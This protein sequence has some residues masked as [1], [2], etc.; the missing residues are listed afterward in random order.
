MR[1]IA[2]GIMNGFVAVLILFPAIVFAAPTG[3]VEEIG[4]QNTYRPGCWTPML[5]SIHPDSAVGTYTLQ[6]VQ[7]DLDKDRVVYSRSIA[8]AGGTAEQRFWTC[9]LPQPTDGG[10]PQPVEGLAALQAQLKVYLATAEGK[11]IVQL[12]V[13]QTITNIDP[14]DSGMNLQRGNKLILAIADPASGDGV[15]RVNYNDVLGVKENLLFVTA[16]P[17]DLPDDVLA[18]QSVDAIVLMNVDPSTLKTSGKIAAIRQW[19]REGGNLLI[20]ENPMWQKMLGWGDLLPVSYPPFDAGAQ[21]MQGSAERKDAGPIAQWA[22]G[23]SPVNDW[24]NLTGPFRVAVARAVPGSLVADE[25]E[26]P[27]T[28]KAP[29]KTP[30]LV[31]KIYGLGSVTWIGID[32]GEPKFSARMSGWPRIWDHVFGWNNNSFTLWS[33]TNRAEQTTVQSIEDTYGIAHGIDFGSALLGGME[34]AGRSA[35]LLLVAVVFFVIYWFLAGPVSFVFLVWRRQTKQSWLLFAGLSIVATGLT[36]VLVKLVLGG[37][38]DAHHVSVVRVAANEPAV[39]R[40]GIGLYFPHDSPA[41]PVELENCSGDSTI[42]PYPIYPQQ[43]RPNS[44]AGYMQYTIPVRAQS[45]ETPPVIGIPFRSTLKKLKAKWIG[46]QPIIEGNAQ[47][48]SPGQGM[49]KGELTNGVGRNLRDVYLVFH[50]PGRSADAGDWAMYISTWPKNQSVDLNQQFETSA[51]VQMDNEPRAVPGSAGALK[52]RIGTARGPL[53]W[54]RFWFA[55]LRGGSMEQEFP[56]NWDPY[57]AFV[58]CSLYERLPT[59]RNTQINLD[60]RFEMRRR[61]MRLL[62][63]SQLI[64]DGAMVGLARADGPLPFPLKVGGDQ[65]PG[66]GVV[67]YQFI[68]P[69][70]HSTGAAKR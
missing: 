28:G 56:S 39:V 27:G 52:G 61:G 18:Y 67:Y 14:A 8:L 31:R 24:K 35:A 5:V 57:R 36:V 10:L 42:I 65:V 38:A 47:L 51:M 32:L 50:V 3:Q 23:G 49:L 21:P 2:R 12:P 46:R 44:Y 43:M 63:A 69:L 37:P 64:A 34:H 33:P 53:E 55:G 41:E 13:T 22:V 6:V 54:G 48:L 25:I 66:Q 4:F 59:P 40:S 70:D 19:V 62:D 1:K 29:V 17:A 26:W 11:P 15:P 9:F 7:N 30:Y 20:C 60:S 58:I 45:D 16:T 68:I